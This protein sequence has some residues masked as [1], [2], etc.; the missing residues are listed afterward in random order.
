MESEELSVNF[1]DVSGV[2][3]QPVLRDRVED[4][5]QHNLRYRQA[6]RDYD[7]TNINS[8]VVSIPVPDDSMGDPKVVGEGAE[9]PRDQE[10]YYKETLEFEK[11]GFEVA[12]TMEAQ[13]DSRAGLVRDQV[14]R[15][16]RQMREE[17]NAQAFNVLTDSITQ[18]AGDANGTFAFD[19][20]L[21]GR[22]TLLTDSYDPDLLIV[23]VAGAHD[24][25]GSNNFLEATD[26]QSSMRRSAEIGEIAGM[27]VVEDDS[28]LNLTG[29]TNPGGLMVDTDFLGYEGTRDPVSTEGYEEERSQTDVFRI[30]NRMG[31]LTVQPNAGVIIDG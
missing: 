4:I 2:L 8:D 11:F 17:M 20:V 21:K 1:D 27:S 18:T 6:F 25:L 31:W 12:L 3:S 28:G 26:D 23:D 15:Q 24:L 22:E 9:F 29:N 16:A 13:E 19:D 7:A 14:D 30:W 5:V 10:T